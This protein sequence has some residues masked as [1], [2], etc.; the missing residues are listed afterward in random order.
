ML[1]KN[2]GRRLGLL[3]TAMCVAA[4]GMA[5]ALSSPAHA[6]D[7]YYSNGVSSTVTTGMTTYTQRTRITAQC[8]GFPNKVT[9]DWTVTW[10]IGNVSSTNITVRGIK[11]SVSFVSGTANS[12]LTIGP[13][14]LDPGGPVFDD[15]TQIYANGTESVYREYTVSPARNFAGKVTLRV[16]WAETIPDYCQ[17][18]DDQHNFELIGKTSTTTPPDE[19]VDKP[20]ADGDGGPGSGAT[21]PPNAL[22]AAEPA[23]VYDRSGSSMT[24]HRWFSTGTNFERLPDYNS[25]TFTMTR[26]GNR[27]AVGDVDGDGYDDIVMAYQNWDNPASFSYYVW[28]KGYQFAGI[29][30]TSGSFGLDKVGGRLVVGDFNNDN[31]AEPAMA[32]AENDGTMTIYRWQST[33]TSFARAADYRSSG[34]FNLDRVADRIAAGDVDGDGDDDIVMTYQ[35]Y[36]NSFTYYTYKQGYTPTAPWYTSGTFSLDPVGNRMLL[37]DWNG[38][39]KDEPALVYDN[40][41]ST[42]KTY[43]WLSNGSSFSR[44]TDYQSGSF[45]LANVKN[46]VA[47]GDVDGD[48]KD[49]IVLAYQRS[50]GRADLHVF[51]NGGTTWGNIW[52][53]T[54]QYTLANVEERIVVGQW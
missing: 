52:S 30:Y 49:D 26:V 4:A 31:K 10:L 50:D 19:N 22:N 27:V 20:S 51:K 1:L 34:Q 8:T 18:Q 7:T 29:W 21:D 15:Y 38:D 6:D 36:D 9:R 39:G 33:G 32:Y 14:Y 28:K 43:R 2:A 16:Q 48:G 25:G 41:N 40:G 11:L 23:L 17:V 46:R 13:R 47:A 54:G 35:N 45:T 37:G 42:F 24:I 44:T 3:G 53:T 5:V 12:T